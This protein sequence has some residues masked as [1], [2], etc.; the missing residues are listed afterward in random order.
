MTGYLHIPEPPADALREEIA[1]RLRGS[2][3][4]S[5]REGASIDLASYDAADIL[6]DFLRGL[7]VEPTEDEFAERI[8]YGHQTLDLGW[9]PEWRGIKYA[10][11]QRTCTYRN[12]EPQLIDHWSDP[13]G[14]R[15]PFDPQPVDPPPVPVQEDQPTCEHGEGEV[16]DGWSADD[17]HGAIAGAAKRVVQEDRP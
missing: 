14:E 4:S 2:F 16:P 6:L 8:E 1:S 11:Y 10:S 7:S 9:V 15:K 12:G 5:W 17:W 13:R 3:Y